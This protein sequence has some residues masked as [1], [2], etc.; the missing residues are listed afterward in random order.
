MRT[1]D[2]KPALIFFVANT[3]WYLWNFRK[4]TIRNLAAEGHAVVCV[5]PD[6]IRQ[7]QLE[8]LGAELRSCVLPKNSF[9]KSVIWLFYTIYVVAS[10]RPKIIFSFTTSAN[11]LSLFSGYLLRIPVVPNI[12]TGRLAKQS[13]PIS[14]MFLSAYSIL[15]SKSHFVIFQNI[16]DKSC[17]VSLQQEILTK[18]KVIHGSGVDL[19]TF[20]YTRMSCA[21]R[22]VKVAFMARLMPEK[23]LRDLVRAVQ[24][25]PKDHFSL[26]IAGAVHPS[27]HNAITDTEL[28]T[29]AKN[30]N[31]TYLGSVENVLPILQDSDLIALPSYYGE[32]FPRFL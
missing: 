27:R 17:F 4:E 24:M 22:G 21:R 2:G 18:C 32:E 15:C 25:L 31:I 14:Q 16:E 23:G 26:V 3:S 1:P 13:R 8:G 9:L 12:R 20:E 6:R 10:Y 30:E 28:L 11:F 5:C 7:S 29:W 19:N